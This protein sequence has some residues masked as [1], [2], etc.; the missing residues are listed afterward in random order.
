M[1]LLSRKIS[2]RLT[3]KEYE[4]LRMK[5]ELS[6]YRSMSIF[7]RDALFSIRLQR[8]N[9]SKTDPNLVRQVAMLRSEIR[10][11]G[12]NYNQRVKTLNT[13][14]KLRDKKGNL[15]VNARDIDRDM[16][17]MKKMM[18]GMTTLVNEAYTRVMETESP[19]SGDSDNKV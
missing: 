2:V 6:G 13:L 16:L 11:I 4:T 12:V 1:D 15:I 3:E 14:A 10:Q 5:M 19:D 17:E 7:I 8:R 18:E 9:Y